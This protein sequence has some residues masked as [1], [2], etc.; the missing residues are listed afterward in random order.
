MRDVRSGILC[1]GSILIDVNT[2][3]DRYPPQEHVAIIEEEELDSGGPA[4]NMAVNLSRLGAP[5]PVDLVGLLG[6]DAHGRLALEI[7]RRAGIGTR[8]VAVRVGL[9]TSY[10]RVMIVR[11]DGRRTFFHRKGANAVLSA[12]QF[13]FA[14]AAAKIFH[15]GAPGVHDELDRPTEGGNGFSEVLARAKKAGLETNLELVSVA[16]ERIRALA[17]PCL[18]H[19]DFIVIN[20]VEASALT[21][22][23]V[24]GPGP[25]W[26]AAG[27]AARALLALGVSRLA[28]IHFP[29]GAVAAER[30]GRDYRQG[31]VR[32]PPGDI[33][34]TNG[35]GDAFASGVLFGLHEGHPVQQCLKAGACV[36]AVSLASH[37]PSGAIRPL[38]ECL[39]YGERAGYRPAR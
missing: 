23:P 39:A 6:D 20:E 2:V 30:G 24:G 12:T 35:A 7:C 17:R 38:A 19:L 26:P 28:V 9:A 31:S 29:E 3:V 15:L 11:G 10:T 36:A 27:A 13:D 32:V 18:P 37:G 8:G 4:F 25:D 34:S 14:G 33:K 21:G 1:G 5:F 16:P 22:V